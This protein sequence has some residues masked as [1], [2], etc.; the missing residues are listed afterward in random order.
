MA[1]EW[2]RRP[3]GAFPP[4]RTGVG[5]APRDQRAQVTVPIR[6]KYE[7]FI[8]FVETQSINISKSGMFV[9][10]DEALPLGTM[11]EFEF[12]LADGFPLLRGKAEVVRVGQ[13]PPRGLGLKF[14]HLDPAS[15]QLIERIV[16][17]NTRERKKP[18]VS[19][20]FAQVDT[21][22]KLKGL[23]GATPVSGG[24]VWGEGS[25]SIA[26]NTVTVSYFVY[27]PLLN[28]RLGG[29]VVP[30]E[31]EVPLGT[32]YQIQISSLAGDLLFGGKGKVVAK[33]EMRLGIRLVADDKA[34]LQRLQAEVAK[35]VPANK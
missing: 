11:L 14:H 34:A 19:M 9:A 24:V 28:I 16:E 27:N 29:F 33:H 1:D 32:V 12:V 30:S 15:V 13:V 6:Y 10:T 21:G 2:T 3:T 25:L 17:I 20:D 8:D 22:T 26:L 18:T 31:R 7:S 23:A 5:P 35:L 4:P